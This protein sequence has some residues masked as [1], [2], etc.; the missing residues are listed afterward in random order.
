MF[1][2][3]GLG[4]GLHIGNRIGLAVMKMSCDVVRR[5]L[6]HR[7]FISR[8]FVHRFSIPFDCLFQGIS[9]SRLSDIR[10]SQEQQEKGQRSR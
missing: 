7:E 2:R 4:S 10:D 3:R 9:D 6:E 5:L 1:L 8:C